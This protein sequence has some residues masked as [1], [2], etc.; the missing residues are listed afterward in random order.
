MP[1]VAIALAGGAILGG[2]LGILGNLLSPKPP[3]PPS[4]PE[5]PTLDNQKAKLDAAAQAERDK[6]RK[7]AN[8]F[9]GGLQTGPLISGTQQNRTVL[10]G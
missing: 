3:S 4:A 7:V 2:A 9:A 8:I 1:P 10:N 6:R 5:V